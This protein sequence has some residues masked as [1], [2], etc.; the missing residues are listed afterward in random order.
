MVYLPPTSDGLLGYIDETSRLLKTIADLAIK[1]NVRYIWAAFPNQTY[2]YLFAI[3][4][5]WHL[6]DLP[7]TFYNTQSNGTSVNQTVAS[8]L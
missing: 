3:P 7:Y 5:S 1:C 6:N 2:S 4:P 8:T